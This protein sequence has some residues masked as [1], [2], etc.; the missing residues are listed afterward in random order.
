MPHTTSHLSLQQI[1]DIVARKRRRDLGDPYMENRL[2]GLSERG[3]TAADEAGIFGMLDDQPLAGAEMVD[4]DDP[5]L[6]GEYTRWYGSPNWGHFRRSDPQVSPPEWVA[7]PIPSR[8]EM[9]IGR[10]MDSRAIQD[11]LT[12]EVGHRGHY[13][14]GLLGTQAGPPRSYDWATGGVDPYT[15]TERIMTP[16]RE[17]RW[18]NVLYGESEPS[19]PSAVTGQWRDVDIP[20]FERDREIANQLAANV[21]MG[22]GEG[23]LQPPRA[24]HV[25]AATGGA[26]VEQFKIPPPVQGLLDVV[27]EPRTKSGIGGESQE[28]PALPTTL[29]QAQSMGEAHYFQDGEKKLAVTADQLAQFKKSDRYDAESKKSALT[30][31]A[32]IAGKEGL[33]GLI[34]KKTIADV[35][36]QKPGNLSGNDKFLANWAKNYYTGEKQD[37]PK[38]LAKVKSRLKGTVP[39]DNKK[40]V[41]DAISSA[42]KIFGTDKMAKGGRMNEAT[43]KKMLQDLGQIES[44]YRTRIAGG[45][46]PERGF[47]QVLPS[48]AKDALKN[49]KG[50]FGPKFNKKFAEY[51]GYAGLSKL[52]KKELSDLLEKDDALGAAFAA[53]Q[54]LRT[55]DK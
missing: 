3:L 33:S 45:G 39:K 5:G 12:H 2:A 48:T 51:G 46:R 1:A 16:E 47:W 42:V 54:V 27:T 17:D 8:D 29:K 49:A 24:P 4:Y 34:P 52:S 23:L 40:T 18:H 38:Y 36:T 14:S 35:K 32:N 50:Y 37:D 31:W 11:V 22:A 30:Q 26:E 13:L 20:A 44:G 25:M 53:V 7:D 55:F 28:L 6:R 9:T 21:E 10:G 19:M 43:M 15:E 41:S